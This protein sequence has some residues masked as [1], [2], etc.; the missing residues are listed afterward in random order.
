MSYFLAVDAGGT[1]AEFLLAD[2]AHELAR[3]T[4]GSIKR[5]NATAEDAARELDEAVSQLTAAS[6]VPMSQISATCIG[7][8]GN[9]VPLVVDW[10][11]ENF[12]RRVSG[13]LHILGDVEIALDAVFPGDRGIL[14]LSGT[15][16]NVAG[17][18]DDGKIVTAGGWGPMLADQGAGHWI[19]LEALRR[20][21]LAID[22]QRDTELLE[23]ARQ[24]WGLPTIKALIEHGN[25]EPRPRF[26]D[27]A[28]IVME[29]ADTGDPI[30]AGILEQ[31][32]R[33]LAALA[34]LVIERILTAE[35]RCL[36][37]PPV[38]IAGSILGKI[39]CVRNALMSALQVRY[40]AIRFVV[41]PADPVL[42]A[43]YR[44]RARK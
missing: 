7:T 9:T 11:R 36:P 15:G 25:A 5:L 21:F 37:L 43:L 14:V 10:L 30:A 23:K 31:G 32:G 19:G 42:G 1:K 13:S 26:A 18:G 34:Q 27:L 24:L 2:D 28:P 17:R 16:S 6:G 3:A 40:P 8:S 4:V 29:C 12:A 38:A 22:E 35:Q 41:E 39:A 33:D 20:G 44:A